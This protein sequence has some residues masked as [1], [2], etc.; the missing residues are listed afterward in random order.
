MVRILWGFSVLA[1]ESGRLPGSRH[2]RSGSPSR[3]LRLSPH[4]PCL[5]IVDDHGMHV[6]GWKDI[7]SE[8]VASGLYINFTFTVLFMIVYQTG[9]TGVKQK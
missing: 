3:S 4:L 1:L 8:Y 9:Y 5:Y 6:K 2:N 7:I